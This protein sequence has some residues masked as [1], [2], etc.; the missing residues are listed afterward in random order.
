MAGDAEGSILPIGSERVPIRHWPRA[1]K[2]AGAE[3]AFVRAAVFSGPFPLRLITKLF[4]V[5]GRRAPPAGLRFA[6]DR[7]K[8][9]DSSRAIHPSTIFRH[10]RPS[11]RGTVNPRP[12]PAKIKATHQDSGS[13]KTVAIAQNDPKATH[14]FPY[15]L[16]YFITT[17]IHSIK[18]AGNH[19]PK[20]PHRSAATCAARNSLPKNE[21]GFHLRLHADNGTPFR[22]AHEDIITK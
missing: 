20:I 10:D 2:T 19:H 18:Q 22:Y 15:P 8:P 16:L 1:A 4:F 14:R 13:V 7:H 17:S 21:F 6:R 9:A 11:Q 5:L 12:S 3:F